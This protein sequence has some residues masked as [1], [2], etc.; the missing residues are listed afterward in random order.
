MTEPLVPLQACQFPCTLQD[1]KS[2]LL[3]MKMDSGTPCVKCDKTFLSAKDLTNHL[4]MHAAMER[5]E[6]LA[7]S[8]ESLKNLKMQ[9]NVLNM[10]LPIERSKR[11]REGSDEVDPPKRIKIQDGAKEI[12]VNCQVDKLICKICKRNFKDA[13]PYKYHMV[14]NHGELDSAYLPSTPSKS[15]ADTSSEQ[16]TPNKLKVRVKSQLGSVEMVDIAEDSPIKVLVDQSISEGDSSIKFKSGSVG[17]N[18]SEENISNVGKFPKSLAEVRKFNK[19]KGKLNVKGNLEVTSNGRSKTQQSCVNIKFREYVTADSESDFE[20]PEKEAI[21][22]NI[23]LKKTLPERG[24]EVF[25]KVSAVIDK[26]LLRNGSKLPIITSITK[27]RSL[28]DS[29]NQVNKKSFEGPKALVKLVA[30]Y[31]NGLGENVVSSLNVVPSDKKFDSSSESQKSKSKST[32]LSEY[33]GSTN[34]SDDKSKPDKSIGSNIDQGNPASDQTTSKSTTPHKSKVKSESD[35]Y[36]P[37]SQSS[38]SAT[39]NSEIEFALPLRKSNRVRGPKPPQI[40]DP[41]ENSS[42]KPKRKSSETDPKTGKLSDP[43]PKAKR[44]SDP[45]PKLNKQATYPAFN[46]SRR[47]SERKF[48]GAKPFKCNHCPLDFSNI[49]SKKIHE[50]THEEKP[51]QCVY[52]D[53]R[54]AIELSLKK[55]SRIHKT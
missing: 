23:N 39:A 34:L 6:D 41:I 15:L 7:K 3:Q 50:Q 27:E 38:D 33:S 42:S 46:T 37:E 43:I 12:S 28:N 48:E 10:S 29:C 17:I 8:L 11:K 54:F 52:C 53:M 20:I 40:R 44:T 1:V 18:E 9:V 49:D 45:A 25:K 24:E 31:S 55:H 22:K 35:S 21:S 4:A 30:N 14:V 13:Q 26:V 5:R 47:L 36:N 51:Y 19:G 16:F 32:Y 2:T